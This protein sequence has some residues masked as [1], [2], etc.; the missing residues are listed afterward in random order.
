[1]NNDNK[2]DSENVPVKTGVEWE[3]SD[4]YPERRGSKHEKSWFKT[5]VGLDG[6]EE[7]EKMKC[8][9]NVYWCLRNS[10]SN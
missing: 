7:L 4:L 9:R 10:T 8:E 3:Y 2:N 6:K 5:L 1:M